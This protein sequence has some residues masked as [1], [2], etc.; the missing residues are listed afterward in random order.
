[1]EARLRIFLE[2]ATQCADD[3]MG[4]NSAQITS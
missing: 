4:G 1:M 3:S 2:A